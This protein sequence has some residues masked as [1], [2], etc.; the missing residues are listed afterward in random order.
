MPKLTQSFSSTAIA[1]GS[2]D[3]DSE[4]LELSFVSGRS[5]THENVPLDIWEG[6]CT[7]RSVGNYFATQIK[8]RY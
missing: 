6:L 1:R 3:T 2:Y 4:T 8:D 5:Y 7:A